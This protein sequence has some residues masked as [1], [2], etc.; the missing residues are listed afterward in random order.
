[1]VDDGRVGDCLMMVWSGHEQLRV[2]AYMCMVMVM[3]LVVHALV[4]IVLGGDQ[5]CVG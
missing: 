3:L 4:C 1:M 2:H 5:W